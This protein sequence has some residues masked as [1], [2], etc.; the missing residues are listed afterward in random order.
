M[1]A[2]GAEADEAIRNA[3]RVFAAGWDRAARMSPREAAEAAH[4]AGGPSVDDLEARISACRGERRPTR[5][6]CIE[7][8]ARQLAWEVQQV[9][10]GTGRPAK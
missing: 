4:Y 6:E 5:D 9:N 8:A 2:M 10:N 3:A 1:G 7:A